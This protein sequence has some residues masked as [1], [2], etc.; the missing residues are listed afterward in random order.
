M[1][2]PKKTK[3]ISLILKIL[4]VVSAAAGILKSA[5]ASRNTFMG[6]SRVFMYFTIQS[7]VLIAIICLIGAFLLLKEGPVCSGWYVFKLVGTVAI[8]LTG[9]V[10]AFILAPTMGRLA[11]NLQNTLTHAV[12]PIAAVSDFL[13]VGAY[14]NIKKRKLLYVS[15]PPLAYVI[16]AGIGYVKGWDFA[17]GRNY[18][19]FF[20]NWGSTA[21][22]F[23][24][25]DR[26]PFMGCV[27]W[28]L[29]LMIIIFGSG[30]GI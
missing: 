17:G 5:F 27:W 8:T 24:F 4:V 23:G 3:W 26:L 30:Y 6:G 29:A 9:L 21:G 18:P 16:Y 19:Y 22:A 10:F 2:I 28:I 20:L 25:S 1:A 11:W 15:L 14:G 13:L 12:V 7:N